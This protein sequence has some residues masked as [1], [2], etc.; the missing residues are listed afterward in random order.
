MKT[1][2]TTSTVA[3]LT[4]KRVSATPCI[5]SKYAHQGDARM[6]NFVV[7]YDSM[8][9]TVNMGDMV[10]V[11]TSITWWV[12]D[13]IYLLNFPRQSDA[14]PETQILRRVRRVEH[15]NDRYQI[16]CDNQCYDGVFEVTGEQLDIAG[17]AVK[18]YSANLI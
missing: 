15:Q 18:V 9:P 12:K 7:E 2:A 8:A 5:H 4:A 17:L 14:I 16:S 13:G 1:I 3:A 11:D 6:M 10:I